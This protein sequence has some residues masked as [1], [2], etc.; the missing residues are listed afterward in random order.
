MYYIFL[1]KIN[2]VI[3]INS[4]QL[5]GISLVQDVIKLYSLRVVQAYMKHIQENAE[6]SVRDLLK[7]VALKYNGEALVAEDFMD[8][9]SRIALVVN[10]DALSGSA[11]FD[12]R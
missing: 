8:D 6:L 5:Q 11:V 4:I 9:G 1:L 3:L 7:Q 2:K 12:F 10:I